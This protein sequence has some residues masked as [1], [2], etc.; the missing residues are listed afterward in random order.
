M[1]HI[2][3]NAR[4][5]FQTIKWAQSGASKNAISGGHANSP[6]AIHRS[7]RSLPVRALNLPDGDRSARPSRTNSAADCWSVHKAFNTPDR[8]APRI[9]LTFAV[10]AATA[11]VFGIRRSSSNVRLIVQSLMVD[12]SEERRVGKE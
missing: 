6:I 9:A 11:I 4:H 10:P 12:R 1:L 3:D 2:E 7:P 5:V 8:N